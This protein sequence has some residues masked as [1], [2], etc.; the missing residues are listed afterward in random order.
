MTNLTDIL[1]Y[2][3]KEY[4]NR[5]AIIFG[6]NKFTYDEVLNRASAV[7]CALKSWQVKKGERIAILLDN[8][9]DFI[10]CYFGVLLAGA[11]VVPINHMFKREEAKYILQDSESVGILTSS[12]Y[13]EMAL[14]LNVILG[15]LKF[16]ALTNKNTE[17]AYSLSEYL[18]GKKHAELDISPKACEDGELAVFLYTS[19][20]TGHPKAA[21]LTHNNLLSNAIS[22]SK[23]IRVAAGDTF[24]C[25]LPLF[26]SFAAT[27][28]MIMPLLNGAKT[29]IMKSPRPIKKLLRAIR[30]N[31]VTIFVGIPSLYQILAEMKLPKFLAP[32][33]LRFFNPVRL[34]IS[35]AAA[36]PIEVFLKF[37]KKYGI[38][39]LE[40]YGLT[41]AS[42]VVSL[43]PLKGRRK[44]GSIGLPIPDTKVKIT[45]EN[46]TSLR[47][48]QIGELCVK[49][50]GVMQGYFKRSDENETVLRDGWLMTGDMAKLDSENY[51]TIM[52]RKK[53]MVNVR[54]LN[55]YPREIEEVLYQHP[56]I[57]EAAVI[58]IPDLHKGEVPKCYCVLK[59]EGSLTEHQIIAYLKEHLALY[60]IPRR[61]EIRKELPKNS[62]GKILKRVLVEENIKNVDIKIKTSH[63]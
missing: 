12:A 56:Q 24:I 37:E 16:V 25:F 61:V 22:S 10:F 40:G 8:S 54:G 4:P 63:N 14:E 42:P 59:A 49:G 62:S 34:A 39:L 7:A 48:E 58:G 19:G 46:G 47:A 11:V 15:S 18:D 52:G 13:S 23:T 43:N 55:V 51:I 53:E 9:P 17:N 21:M 20:T 36:L 33:L 30:K 44:P 38:P 6:Q 60:K 41:E 31:K 57:K 26:H 5:T 45:D 29:V 28:C 2:G 1:H 35:G 3:S 50:P 27:V 32:W